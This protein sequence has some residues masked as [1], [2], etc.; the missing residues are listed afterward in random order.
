[1][2][3]YTY[4]LYDIGVEQSINDYLSNFMFEPNRNI[5]DKYVSELAIDDIITACQKYMFPKSYIF[6]NNFDADKI[7]FEI[8]FVE[9]FIGN[10]IGFETVPLFKLKLK[11]FLNVKMPKYKQLFDSIIDFSEYLNT[12]KSREEYS[13][14]ENINGD[15]NS[16]HNTTDTSKQELKETNKQI[17]SENTTTKENDFP[18]AVYSSG[19][20]AT[21]GST[22]TKSINDQNDNTQSVTDEKNVVETTIDKTDSTRDN[23]YTK[24]V[25]GRE[26]ADVSTIVE[27]YRKN[28]LSINDEIYKEAEKELFLKIW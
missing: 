11:N 9:K 5:I 20:Y 10:E 19:D 28:I 12:N 23:K 27:K 17:S 4:T 1:M 26:G 6:Y 15:K 2:S 18:Q 25:E 8:G 21:A 24:T 14:S 22:N 3:K 13:G 7:S 16:T